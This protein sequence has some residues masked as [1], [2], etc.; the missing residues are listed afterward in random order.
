MPTQQEIATHLGMDQGAVSRH[1]GVLGLDWKTASMDEIRLAYLKHLR[2]VAAGHQS[3]DGVDLTYERAM[4]ERVDREIKLLTLAEKRG[5]VVNLEQLEP[6][7]SRM[8]GAFR[9]ALLARDDKLKAEVDALYGINLDLALLNDFTRSALSQLARYDA[10]RGGFAQS[11]GGTD[12][13]TRADGYHRV[14]AGAP[15]AVG[16]GECA[17]R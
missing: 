2:A 1:L 6:E 5:Q 8:V 4:T 3:A 17:T 12:G 9:T 7:L 13:A 11:P 14:G 15:Q 16:Q 10:E